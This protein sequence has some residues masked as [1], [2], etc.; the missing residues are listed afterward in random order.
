MT[1]FEAKEEGKETKRSD[2]IRNETKRFHTIE[3][4]PLLVGGVWVC[5]SDFAGKRSLKS[6]WESTNLEFK[7]NQTWREQTEIDRVGSER[8]EGA[9]TPWPLDA[10]FMH[11]CL[12]S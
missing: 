10:I 7:R 2:V 11:V 5:I 3:T 12:F 8:G 1:R 4:R 6:S 9:L